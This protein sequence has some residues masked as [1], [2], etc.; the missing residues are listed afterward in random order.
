MKRCY[1]EDD[2]LLTQYIKAKHI[3]LV[4]S[5]SSCALIVDIHMNLVST[6]ERNVILIK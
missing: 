4:Q 1:L 5:Y 3:Y 2:Y 6:V